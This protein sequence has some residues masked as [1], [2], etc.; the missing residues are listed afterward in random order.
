MSRAVLNRFEHARRVKHF[1]EMWRHFQKLS[2]K[3]IQFH[4]FPGHIRS[5]NVRVRGKNANFHWTGRNVLNRFE[6]SFPVLSSCFQQPKVASARI[7]LVNRQPSADHFAKRCEQ[8]SVRFFCVLVWEGDAYQTGKRRRTKW[9]LGLR[10]LEAGHVNKTLG[11]LSS[12]DG[13]AARVNWFPCRFE[14]AFGWKS[15]NI[16]LSPSLCYDYHLCFCWNQIPGRLGDTWTLFFSLISSCAV[17]RSQ[18]ANDRHPTI[19][20]KKQNEWT[21]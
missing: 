4:H 17:K 11:L 1:G 19:I 7:P 16:D 9:R 20:W 21:V 3:L 15:A 18:T 6:H 12:L 8:I 13:D 2:N 5:R 14:G 10:P